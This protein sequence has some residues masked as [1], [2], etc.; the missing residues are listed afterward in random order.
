[1]FE[2]ALGRLLFSLS[3]LLIKAKQIFIFNFTGDNESITLDTPSFRI[4]KICQGNNR[5][6]IYYSVLINLCNIFVVLLE[7]LM[8]FHKKFSAVK[9]EN[10]RHYL[11]GSEKW[12]HNVSYNNSM[13]KTSLTVINKHDS[14]ARLSQYFKL[15]ALFGILFRMRMLRRI[16]IYFIL[17]LRCAIFFIIF[18]YFNIYKY[19]LLFVFIF[20]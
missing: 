12:S 7:F 8:V 20:F 16:I 14:L 15:H 4:I 9:L 3:Y 11:P 19:Q 6:K 1:M 2:N 5:I 10:Y 18:L 17:P 13:E